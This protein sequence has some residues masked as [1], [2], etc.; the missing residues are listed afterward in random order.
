MGQQVAQAADLDNSGDL[1]WGDVSAGF[2]RMGS[3]LKDKGSQFMDY[4]RGG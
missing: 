4:Q 2:G 3:Y 1:G